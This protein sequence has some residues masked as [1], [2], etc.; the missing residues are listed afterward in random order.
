[1]NEEI[2]KIVELASQNKAK[3]QFYSEEETIEEKQI[4]EENHP[5]SSNSNSEH[6]GKYFVIQR[7]K[8][9]CNQGVS[10]PTFKVSSHQK[11]YWN[12]AE[13]QADYLAVTEDDVQ[14]TPSVQPFG[15][16]CKLQPT[17]GGYLPCSYAPAGKWTSCYEK[18]KVLGKSCV[19]EASELQCAIGGKI[20]VKSHGQQSEITKAHVR[21]ANAQ[22]HRIYNPFFD[23]E[24]F[25]NQIEKKDI[26]DFK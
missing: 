10:F 7:G 21:K 15:A 16:Q 8:A 12:D 1:M 2:L 18:V 22:E 25:Q 26:G 11:H 23:F 17:S 9:Q 4:N 20:T 13:G 5:T 19:T 6:D 14:F 3:Y 24:A